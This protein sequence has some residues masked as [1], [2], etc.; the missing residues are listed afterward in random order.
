[1]IEGG[2][3]TTA[4]VEASVA[5]PWQPACSGRRIVGVSP[6]PVTNGVE[7][8]RTAGPDDERPQQAGHTARTDRGQNQEKPPES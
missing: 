1:M 7:T 8:R 4:G 3:R 6:V 2:E 5:R